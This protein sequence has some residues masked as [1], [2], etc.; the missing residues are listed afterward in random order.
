MEKASNKESV[1]PV[2]ETALED[3]PEIYKRAVAQTEIPL[4]GH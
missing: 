1:R 4:S 2:L 3:G